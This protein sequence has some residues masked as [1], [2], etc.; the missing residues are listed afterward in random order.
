[1]FVDLWFT[2]IFNYKQVI[3]HKEGFEPAQL[4]LSYSKIVRVGVGVGLVFYK[5]QTLYL[6]STCNSY[7]SII[8]Y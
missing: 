6:I 7:F 1:M 4:V 3:T 8:K 5:H 2:L